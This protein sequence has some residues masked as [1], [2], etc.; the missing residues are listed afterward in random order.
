MPC[1]KDGVR[2]QKAGEFFNG[3]ADFR[4]Q[5][6]LRACLRFFLTNFPHFSATCRP[7]DAVGSA[8]TSA[9]GCTPCS[10]PMLI[11][12]MMVLAIPIHIRQKIVKNADVPLYYEPRKHLL[13]T[14]GDQNSGKKL[15]A[16][17]LENFGH[18]IALPEDTTLLLPGSFV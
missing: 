14:Y 13:E 16:F 11:G 8:V 4:E 5:L 15:L 1:R 6:Y 7:A 2:A 18:R 3:M 12:V 17:V 9:V 10:A